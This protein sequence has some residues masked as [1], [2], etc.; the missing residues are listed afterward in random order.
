M[1]CTGRIFRIVPKNL[2]FIVSI[3]FPS[4]KTPRSKTFRKTSDKKIIFISILIIMH[5]TSKELYEFISKETQDPIVEW[6]TCT[7][8]WAEFPIYQSDLDFYDKISPTFNGVKYQIPVPTICPEER[9]RRRLMFR[10]KENFTKESVRLQV[11]ILFLLIL[12]I[13]K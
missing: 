2:I 5:Y 6:R 11:K 4:K 13:K 9:Q 3:I 12:Q 10:T 1:W 7:L 8:S